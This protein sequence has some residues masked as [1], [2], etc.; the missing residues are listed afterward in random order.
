MTAVRCLYAFDLQLTAGT[1]CPAHQHPA[2]EI[3]VNLG[4]TGV[5]HQDGTARPYGGSDSL[6][7]Q[8]GANHWV[9]TTTSG[10]QIAVCVTGCGA[11]ALRPGVY[12]AARAAEA[13]AQVRA[14]LNHNG[15]LRQERLDLAAGLLVLALRESMSPPTGLAE[16]SKLLLDEGLSDGRGVGEVA[17]ALHVNPDYLRQVFR[18]AYGISPLHYLIQRRLDRARELLAT[19]D[20]PV[21]AIAE[22]CGIADAFYFAR[23]FRRAT[24]VT[25][26]AWRRTRR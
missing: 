16:Q 21:Q 1:R 5:L 17:T 6:V 7:Y 20:L 26:S 15:P 25:P 8:P 13:A 14:A 11:E 2:T 12:P 9:A 18:K 4:A 19:S 24:G 3:V 10:G 23:L 22:G